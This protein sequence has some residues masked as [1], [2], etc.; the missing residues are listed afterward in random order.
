MFDHEMN[1]DP[2]S[3][4]ARASTY[5]LMESRRPNIKDHRLQHVIEQNCRSLSTAPLL[6]E[7]RIRTTLKQQ[8]ITP[9]IPIDL[10]SK[11][12]SYASHTGIDP[13]TTAANATSTVAL[14]RDATFAPDTSTAIQSPEINMSSPDLI[15]TASILPIRLLCSR[16]LNNE[17]VRLISH[18][19]H[20]GN[21]VFTSQVGTIFKTLNHITFKEK[22]KL[23][24]HTWLASM[25]HMYT[26][27]VQP[28]SLQSSVQL[29][30]QPVTQ[31]NQHNASSQYTS[32][33]KER[34]EIKQNINTVTS[35]HAFITSS[36]LSINGSELQ[37]L[38]TSPTSQSKTASSI[39][40]TTPAS[41][42]IRP[43]TP[44]TIQ[45][46][47]EYAIY[48]ECC[49]KKARTTIALYCSGCGRKH[50]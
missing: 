40:H 45:E 33:V 17:L 1:N 48:C 12:H 24:L 42:Q 46:I 38:S 50:R 23:T 44:L 6:H 36:R 20:D 10:V 8:S 31:A 21:P 43:D 34:K 16:R 27:T 49:G 22:S 28:P 32:S 11:Q 39:P 2:Q 35:A 18:I 30:H 37:H 47:V 13:I 4:S 9:T 14:A 3:I 7:S 19:L 26:V 5:H 29:I 41:N 15:I 25:R